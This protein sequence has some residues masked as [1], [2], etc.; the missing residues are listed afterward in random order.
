M[1]GW[2][3]DYF[4]L[5]LAAE[6][7]YVACVRLLLENKAQID[8]VNADNQ[9]ALHL[10]C[11]A[12]STES[13]EVLI[14]HGANV[15]AVYKDGRNALHACLVK[16]RK[17]FECAKLIING[18]VDINKPDHYG[19][20]ALHLAALNEYSRCAYML[21]GKYDVTTRKFIK[22]SQDNW[23]FCSV[24]NGADI[25]ARTNGGVSALSFIVRRTPDVIPKFFSKFDS[26][27]NV[28]ENEIG[29]VDCEI[30]LDFRLLVPSA[31]RGETELL[32]AFIEVGQKRIL[33]HPLCETFLFL[34]WRRI[35]KF[36]LFSLLYHSIYV[37]MFTFYILGVYDNRCDL[38]ANKPE[39]CKVNKYVAPVG[40]IVLILNSLLLL[41]ELFQVRDKR[42]TIHLTIRSKINISDG[43]WYN[44]IREI[45][46]EL[47][48][49]GNHN[50]SISIGHPCRTDKW[51]FE[52]RTNLA[53]SYSCNNYIFSLARINDARW[54]ISYIRIIC[55]NVYQSGGELF[56]I[57]I[58][59]LL[60]SNRIWVKFCDII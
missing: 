10:A 47:V 43:P 26:A 38:A 4:H 21:I 17:C 14:K 19:Y 20:T 46:G 11:L 8:A 56:E 2:F 3:V 5:I 52:N 15:N 31:E 27:I 37:M 23:S 13:I 1:F 36:F 51:R 57:F 28:N 48:R 59:I 7:D 33:N 39:L 29:D 6:E 35:R 24:E 22:F 41:K 58:S 12:Q 16:E 55:S 60:S 18:G 32:L 49:M 40:F 25:T 30:K 54:E 50:R 44:R 53:I 9:T 42:D 34:K 45:L